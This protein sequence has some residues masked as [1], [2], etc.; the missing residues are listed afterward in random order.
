MLRSSIDLVVLLD[1][2]LDRFEY[3]VNSVA[4]SRAESNKE[5]ELNLLERRALLHE[6]F[7]VLEEGFG[8][9]VFDANGLK[10]LKQQIVLAQQVLD[11]LRIGLNNRH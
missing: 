4:T 10:I 8:V 5:L 1:L 2:T 7:D 9:C 11:I 6:V 3:L